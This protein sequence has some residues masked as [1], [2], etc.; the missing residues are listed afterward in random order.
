MET[1]PQVSFRADAPSPA[2]WEAKTGR[3]QVILQHLGEM[4]CLSQRTYFNEFFPGER[5]NKAQIP[6]P[7]KPPE[8]DLL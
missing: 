7:Q 3:H 4:L 5:E 1:E 8:A 2:P 6:E